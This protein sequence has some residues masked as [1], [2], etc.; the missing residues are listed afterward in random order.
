M[1][2][3]PTTSCGCSGARLVAK[4]EDADARA[5]MIVKVKEPTPND[6]PADQEGSEALQAINQANKTSAMVPP[7]VTLSRVIGLNEGQRAKTTAARMPSGTV[8]RGS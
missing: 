7:N 2:G 5:D 1:P 4:A 3:A 8:T 6:Y